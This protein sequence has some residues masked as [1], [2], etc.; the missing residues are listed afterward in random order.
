MTRLSLVEAINEA[1]HE[2]EC[3]GWG[4]EKGNINYA[5]S[6]I[7]TEWLPQPDQFAIIY[8]KYGECDAC[9]KDRTKHYRV[10]GR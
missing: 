5:E 3:R 4:D 8:F 1:Y 6:H 7:G 10:L 9:K 2:R